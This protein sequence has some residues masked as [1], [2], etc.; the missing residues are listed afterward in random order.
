MQQIKA[1]V[2]LTLADPR[3]AAAALLSTT[4]LR[5]LL[6]QL[7]VI[8]VIFGVILTW[9]TAVLI[10]GPSNP[11]VDALL[12]NP[13]LFAVIQLM[14]LMLSVLAILVIG[15][16]FGGIGSFEQTLFI[17]IWLQFFMLLA[18][19]VL[20]AVAI[21]APTLAGL[22]N[23]ASY[24]YFIWLMVNFIAVLHGFRSLWAVFAGLI[25]TMFALSFVILF[26][27]GV[28]GLSVEGA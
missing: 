20:V 17:M 9:T 5:D 7:A 28:I 12:G 25:A 26:V 14:T 8:V 2:R 27:L 10:P 19:A 18:Q 13:I 16:V 4:P 23:T 1:L 3:G 22:L 21:I 11:F 15:R 24:V 6:L